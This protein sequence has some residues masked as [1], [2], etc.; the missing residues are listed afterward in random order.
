LGALAAQGGA[1]GW[2]ETR[3]LP[4]ELQ[5]A[6]AVLQPG[7]VAGPLRKSADEF[8]LVGLDERRPM[9]ATSLKTAKPIIAQ[10]L[11]AE[12]QQKAIRDWLIIKEQNAKIEV[13]LQPR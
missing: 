11:L 12:K 4:P 3:T 6:V 13:L 7:D 9:Q 5:K 10:K 1:T 8:L 2:V